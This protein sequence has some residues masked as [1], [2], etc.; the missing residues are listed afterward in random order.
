[1]GSGNG[2]HPYQACR[3]Q[4]CDKYAC[5]VWKEAWAEAWAEA[6]GAGYAAGHEDGF[7]EGL[8]SCPGPHSG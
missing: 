1:M 6:F 7:A 3:D 2:Q 5:R 8:R 4:E